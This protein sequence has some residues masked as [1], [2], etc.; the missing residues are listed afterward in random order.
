[1]DIVHRSVVLRWGDAYLRASWAGWVRVEQSRADHTGQ[2]IRE[3]KKLL[4]KYSRLI[5]L[6]LSKDSL[7]ERNQPKDKKK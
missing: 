4:K 5:V 7:K 3:E 1:M 2:N 6:E